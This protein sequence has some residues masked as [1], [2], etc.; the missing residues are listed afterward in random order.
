MRIALFSDIHGN[1]QALQAILEDINNESFDSVICLG[2]IVG[3]GPSSAICLDEIMKFDIKMILGNQE[4]YQVRGHQI[5]NLSEEIIEHI[6][7]VRSTLSEEQIN[8]LEKAP[9]SIEFI[10]RGR[11][12][13][14]SHFLIDD[15]KKEYPFFDIAIIDN[16]NKLNVLSYEYLFFGHAHKSFEIIGT[17]SLYRCISSSG[18]RNNDITSYTVLEIF[19][20]HIKCY[21]KY[22]KY[23]RKKFLK[24]IKSIDYPGKENFMKNI[25]GIKE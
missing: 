18:C 2:D 4:L 12:F 21:E 16:F 22:L 15:E 5:D 19:D 3:I 24:Q 11:L 13:T 23:D 10:N 25:Y 9:L 6:E 7:W 17:N 8:Y 1:Y 20:N 14:F